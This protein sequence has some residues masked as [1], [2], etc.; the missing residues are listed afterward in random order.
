MENSI[1]ILKNYGKIYINLKEILETKKISRSKL[2][3]MTALGYDIINRYYNN[4]VNRIDLDVIS[5]F[6]Y[7]LECNID[8]ILKYHKE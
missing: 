1:Y 8:D 4:K 5:R 7:V 3:T 2:S 6:C